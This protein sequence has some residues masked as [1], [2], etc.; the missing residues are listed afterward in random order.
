M[1]GHKQYD[2]ENPRDLKQLNLLLNSIG[3]SIQRNLIGV[4]ILIDLDRFTLATKRKAGRRTVITPPVV[5]AIMGYRFEGLSPDEIASNL[6]VSRTTVYEVL[7]RYSV[8]ET[9]VQGQLSLDDL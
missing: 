9:A 8:E 6:N 1:K 7:K 5:N 4:Y 2:P 3:V